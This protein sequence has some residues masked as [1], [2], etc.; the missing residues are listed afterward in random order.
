MKKVI[1]VL[2]FMVGLAIGVSAQTTDTLTA[3]PTAAACSRLNQVTACTQPFPMLDS[4]NVYLWFEY[5][6]VAGT[7]K[8]INPNT[9]PLPV[10]TIF[11][12]NDLVATLTPILSSRVD[13]YRGN[14]TITSYTG[15]DGAFTGG[16]MHII[17]RE[18]TSYFTGQGCSGKGG[19]KK[20]FYYESQIVN[21]V[22]GANGQPITGD[23][24][25]LVTFTTN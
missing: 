9:Y 18:V 21:D 14:Y 24:P 7:V 12:A 16:E 4:N 8:V 10:Q 11:T 23:G 19:C 17:V 3:F 25:S 1:A 13:G 20:G 5:D 22:I 6:T 15:V 2:L